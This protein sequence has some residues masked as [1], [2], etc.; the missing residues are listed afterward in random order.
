[1]SPD[2]TPLLRDVLHHMETFTS[3]MTFGERYTN[4]G[5]TALDSLAPLRA[6]VAASSSRAEEVRV[7]REALEQAEAYLAKRLLH[8]GGEGETKVLPAIR[9]ALKETSNG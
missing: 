4:A 6:A 9:S 5:Q 7:L 2:L 1:M 3:E 8:T